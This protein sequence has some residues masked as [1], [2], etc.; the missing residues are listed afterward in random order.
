M[1]VY[2][3]DNINIDDEAKAQ[4]TEKERAR[5]ENFP[6]NQRNSIIDDIVDR[7]D[8]EVAEE[9]G[10][11]KEELAGDKDDDKKSDDSAQK[12]EEE[13]ETVDKKDNIDRDKKTDT[14]D[15]EMIT[16]KVNGREKEY[17]K[18]VVEEHGGIR[19][20]QKELAA[21]EKMR[22]ADEKEKEYTNK[23][24]SLEDKPDKKEDLSD[25]K[26]G[27]DDKS[28][29]KKLSGD[30]LRGKVVELLTGVQYGEPEEFVD[31]FIKI[32]GLDG[33][34]GN[35]STPNG[36]SETELKK[37]VA[38]EIESRESEKE[39]EKVQKRFKEE[40]AP[41]FDEKYGIMAMVEMVN[42]K[43]QTF[44]VPTMQALVSKEA[45]RLIAEEKADINSYETYQKAAKTIAERFNINLEK[46]ADDLPPEKD[47][48]LKIGDDIKGKKV[49]KKKIDNVKGAT[50][51]HSDAKPEAGPQTEDELRTEGVKE[52][53]KSRG[54][55]NY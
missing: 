9:I 38:E 33:P 5:E 10:V 53:M 23:L 15:E 43:P 54:Q 22:L 14:D 28:G 44:M 8:T 3:K 55:N 35:S 27:T 31:D 21:D 25:D 26:D 37:R 47:E 13:S 7:R 32:L 48:S 19:A 2:G 6:L 16:L 18:S 39:A 49:I 12:K 4:E 20:F 24:K 40:F 36:I 42:G 46:K 11:S 41:L 29:K 30:E 1:K 45:D 50:G 51:A 17:K 52:I 34:G